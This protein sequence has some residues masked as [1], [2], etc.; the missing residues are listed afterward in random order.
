VVDELLFRSDQ[1]FANLTLWLGIIEAPEAAKRRT[2]E[3]WK[4]AG[5]PSAIKFAPYIAHVAKVRLFFYIAVAHQV[6]TIIQPYRY[7]IFRI[8]AI[9]ERIF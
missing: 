6:I 7:G 5:R 3:S 2:V 9:R 1:N 8:P 4:R